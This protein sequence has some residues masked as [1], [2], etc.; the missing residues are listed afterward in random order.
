MT[1]GAPGTSS[2]APSPNVETSA[3]AN[4]AQRAVACRPSQE[5]QQWPQVGRA[6]ALGRVG[7]L[8]TRE[9]S[10]ELV[11]QHRQGQLAPRTLREADVIAVTVSQQD[12]AHV[13]RASADR[14]QRFQA[15]ASRIRARR[16]R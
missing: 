5:T 4:L 10:V 8:A 1:R 3:Q 2:V 13:G 15:S 6:K 16:R 11:D 12:R 14:G 7:D 9:R